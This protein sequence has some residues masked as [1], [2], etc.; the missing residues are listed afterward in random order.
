M[1]QQEEK[2][3]IRRYGW[4]AGDSSGQTQRLEGNKWINNTSHLDGTHPTFTPHTA[5]LPLF[6]C[7]SA[8]PFL[9]SFLLGAK[10]RKRDV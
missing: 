2:I 8:S 10:D 7:Y 6:L 9:A 5:R 3:E 1:G 4:S